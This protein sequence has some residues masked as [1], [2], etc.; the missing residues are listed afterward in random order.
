[1]WKLNVTEP[2]TLSQNEPFLIMSVIEGSGLLDGELIKK[3]DHFILPAGYGT[4]HMQGNMELIAS[5]VK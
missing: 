2:V 4:F 5:T 1:M 3:G